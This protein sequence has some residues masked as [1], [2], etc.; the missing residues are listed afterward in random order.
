MASL[1][2]EV[3]RTKKAETK[4]NR[5]AHSVNQISELCRHINEKTPLGERACHL[6]KESGGGDIINAQPSCDRRDQFDFTLILADGRMIQ[7]DANSSKRKCVATKEPWYVGLKMYNGS[8][9]M[10]SL[11]NKY[12]TMWYERFIASGYITKIHG[13]H[14]P[15]PTYDEWIE[16]V[17]SQ[18][19]G[20]SEWTNEIRRKKPRG[21]SEEHIDFVKAFCQHIT[22]DDKRILVNEVIDMAT[23]ALEEKQY[24]VQIHSD[25]NRISYIRWK[26]QISI[27]F[28]IPIVEIKPYKDVLLSLTWEDGR[29]LQTILRWGNTH[30]ISNLRMEIK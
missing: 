5:Y 3:K 26:P 21:F 18:S 17:F 1:C 22:E 29:S 23:R 11:A 10:F 16:D 14:T 9:S 4:P 13:I 25:L 20:N 28:G 2:H 12:S 8:G 24:W 7:V 27:P 15:I 6:F 30:G 19:K